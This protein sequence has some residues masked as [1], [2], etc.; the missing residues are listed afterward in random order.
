MGFVT[1]SSTIQL[2]AY[3]TQYARE[4]IFN[5]DTNEFQAK[6]FSLH[7]EDVNY[8]ITSNL[9]GTINQP[10]TSGFI[11]DIT[12]DPDNCIKSMVSKV[13]TKNMLVGTTQII[14]PVAGCTDPDATNYN[15]AAIID[16]G[17]CTYEP[18]PPS[19]RILTIGF[20]N[21]TNT[22]IDDYSTPINRKNFNYVLNINLL[23]NAGEPNPTT[24]EINTTSFIVELVEP[25]LGDAILASS[26]QVGNKSLPATINFTSSSN[27]QTLLTFSRD[28]NHNPEPSEVEPAQIKLRLI[29][30]NSNRA[31]DPIKQI[32]TYRA[33][34]YSA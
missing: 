6:Y 21:N 11:P 29:S 25:P 13:L 22:P 27:L 4:R 7:D 19:S 32:F 15:S 30:T 2:Y 31:I 18:S 8:K 24:S 14:S 28:I 9:D 3:L 26:I 17:S 16:N 34:I 12:G 33:N 1:S 20:Q 10:L 23:Q 5:G